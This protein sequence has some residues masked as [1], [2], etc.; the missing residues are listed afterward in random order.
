MTRTPNEWRKL[1]NKISAGYTPAGDTTYVSGIKLVTILQ[2]KFKLFSKPSKLK[3]CDVGSGN[4]RLPMGLIALEVNPKSYIGLEI[5]PGCVSFC[6]I[7]F[8][9]YPNFIFKLLNAAN[10]HYWQAA[11]R[12]ELVKYPLEDESVNLVIA[13]SLFSHTQNIPI[14]E[15]NISEMLRILKPGGILY[16]SWII[17][18]KRDPSAAMTKYLQQDIEELL[19]NIIASDELEIMSQIRQTGFISVKE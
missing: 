5:I 4:G 13:N 6:N 15:R 12:P 19:P 10:P 16:S 17:R 18:N 7:A 2:N 8:L 9:G 3:I 14:A 11:Q 1:C